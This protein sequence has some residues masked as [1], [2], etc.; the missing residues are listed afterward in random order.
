MT[1]GAKSKSSSEP[2]DPTDGTRSGT[3]A[4]K[5]R[6]VAG[7][8]KI[9]EVWEYAAE[10]TKLATSYFASK[11]TCTPKKKGSGGRYAKRHDDPIRTCNRFGSSEDVAGMKV[12]ASQTSLPSSL[13]GSTSSQSK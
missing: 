9:V 1:P 8:V 3:S 2:Q 11:P 7:N 12:E 5:H 13:S 4:P 6:A 10:F